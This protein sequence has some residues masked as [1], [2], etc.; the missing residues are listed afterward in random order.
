MSGQGFQFSPFGIVPLP[1]SETTDAADETSFSPGVVALAAPAPAPI[2]PISA[3]V[4]RSA[5]E[6]TVRVAGLAP[7]D[8][9]KL[10][11]Q[12]LRDINRELKHHEKLKREK[13]Q[14]ERLVLA[15]KGKLVAPVRSID[16]ARRSAG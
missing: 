1:D 10:A 7:K 15:A 8:V 12:R 16:S 13:A 5:V 4:E 3:S 9:V 6:R 2:G 11:K 14:L